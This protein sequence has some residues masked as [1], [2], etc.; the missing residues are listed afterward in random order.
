MRYLLVSAIILLLF[1][2]RKE[3]STW[4]IEYNG[5]LAR[6]IISVQDLVQDSS[7]SVQDDGVVFYY[8]EFELDASLL[9]TITRLPDTIIT[10]SFDTGIPFAIDVPPGIELI[11]DA[12]DNEITGG[13]FQLR[14]ARVRSGT[15]NYKVKS[16]INGNIDY[17]YTLPGVTINQQAIS[18]GGLANPGTPDNPY[19]T[20]GELDLANC[21]IDFTGETGTQ[22]NSVSSDLVIGTSEAFEEGAALIGNDSLAIELSYENVILEYAKGYFGQYSFEDEVTESFDLLDG[23]VDGSFQPELFSLDVSLENTVGVDVQLF[24]G[25]IF[26]INTENDELITISSDEL[27]PVYNLSRALDIN[28]NVQVVD[29]LNISLDQSNSNVL[30]LFQI[31]PNEVSVV[32]G[33]EINP[34]G[35]ISSGNDFYYAD[36]PL[37]P[38]VALNIP[39]CFSADNVLFRDTLSLN[40]EWSVDFNEG[41]L[42]FEISNAFPFSGTLSLNV[43][44]ENNQYVETLF[45]GLELTLPQS[46]SN[47]EIVQAGYSEYELPVQTSTIN[48]LQPGFKLAFEWSMN[49]A[50]N[51]PVKIRQEHQIGIEIKS[52]FNTTVSV[53]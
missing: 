31:L 11:S 22:Y 4:D 42:Y 36:H 37:N 27:L 7:L 26:L 21:E 3:P 15:L 6:S 2:C 20:F 5:P 44:D 51:D 39:L 10:V 23:I 18:I 32:T 38:R 13:D 53:K 25:D 48:H 45:E 49:T 19:E 40:E 1:S 43:L 16:Y 12:G 50:G 34:L 28:G 46:N 30:E 24:L 35:D 17:E 33:I 29:E 8:N 47:F 41:E 9:D 14:F 52:R